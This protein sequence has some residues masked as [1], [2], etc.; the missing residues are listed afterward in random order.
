MS[1]AD[2]DFVTGML[3]HPEVMRYWPKCYDRNEAADWIRRQQAR[4]AKDGVG[5]WQD[6]TGQDGLTSADTRCVDITGHHAKVLSRRPPD[7]F[8]KGNRITVV[9]HDEQMALLKPRL[10][11][12]VQAALNQLTTKRTAAVPRMN[13]QMVD[14]SSSAVMAAKNGSNEDSAGDSDVTHPRVALQVRLDALP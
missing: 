7:R 10:R 5:Y 3:A 1:E 8:P 6:G 2:L 4:Y 14:E 11:Q 13:R 9:I 12:R